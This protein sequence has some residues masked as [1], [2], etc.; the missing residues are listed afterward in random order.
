MKKFFSDIYC[1]KK[2]LE[3]IEYGK[4]F[5]K[6][7]NSQRKL[8]QP[9]PPYMYMLCL[10]LKQLKLQNFINES[11][12]ASQLKLMNEASN[13]DTCCATSKADWRPYNSN[14]ISRKTSE[15]FKILWKN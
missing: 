4:Y 11:H 14:D 5:V 13:F 3:Q 12:Y 8:D 10:Y 6:K 1:W 7:I 2:Y 15:K 9:Q